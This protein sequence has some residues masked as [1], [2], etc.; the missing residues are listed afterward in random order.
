MSS[1]RRSPDSGKRSLEPE[2]PPAQDEDATGEDNKVVV[3]RDEHDAVRTK[4]KLEHESPSNTTA[5]PDEGEEDKRRKKDAKESGNTKGD[6]TEREKASATG[7]RWMARDAEAPI[8]P[9]VGKGSND[10]SGWGKL[11]KVLL[12]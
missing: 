4:V 8:T 7:L 1:T 11:P 6:E 5:Q 9:A 3:L 12:Q 10:R 2:R